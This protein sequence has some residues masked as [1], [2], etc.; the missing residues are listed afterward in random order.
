MG[1]QYLQGQRISTLDFKGFD[2]LPKEQAS[3]SNKV[4]S[5]AAADLVQPASC[6]V[7]KAAGQGS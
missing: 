7:L 1:D 3:A 6:E 5:R 2:G 4:G